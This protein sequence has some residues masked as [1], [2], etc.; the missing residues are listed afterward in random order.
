MVRARRPQ[1]K[2]PVLLSNSSALGKLPE[3]RRETVF[4][5]AWKVLRPRQ[6]PLEKET[7]STGTLTGT[8]KPSAGCCSGA[9]V[10]SQQTRQTDGRATAQ[11]Y[12]HQREEEEEKGATFQ[13]PP[14]VLR[15]TQP[16]GGLHP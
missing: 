4:Q 14:T 2:T 13:T 11:T 15:T 9:K 8:R 16:L 12:A 1:S 3:P 7:P 6:A 10:R 5:G